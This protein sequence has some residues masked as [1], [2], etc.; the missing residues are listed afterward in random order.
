[1]PDAYEV[2]D[3]KDHLAWKER[4][5]KFS[6]PF[7]E[8][9]NREPG[10]AWLD[11]KYW[12]LHAIGSGTYSATD[13]YDKKNTHF[14]LLIEGDVDPVWID[15]TMIADIDVDLAKRNCR[16]TIV[17]TGVPLDTRTLITRLAD[18]I[19]IITVKELHGIYNPD[20][21]LKYPP[22]E[23][24][25]Y[26]CLMQ[27]LTPDRM[28]AAVELHN[29]KMLDKGIVSFI[30]NFRP[31]AYFDEF[32]RE[33]ASN[34]DVLREMQSWHPR[35]TFHYETRDED[36]EKIISMVPYRSFEEPGPDGYLADVER[37]AQFSIVY[38]TYNTDAYPSSKWYCLTEKSTRS[39][40]LPTI[41]LFCMPRFSLF[42][43]KELGF[44]F[45]PINE[46]L[47]RV[48]GF[49]SQ[50]NFIIG[51]LKHGNIR[52]DPDLEYSIAQHN[53]NVLQSMEDR[54]YEDNFIPNLIRTIN[55]FR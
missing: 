21:E 55:E 42:W 33:G 5:R 53:R 48:S 13:Y 23:M 15:A 16:L 39:L 1:M 27:R 51:M 52:F 3:S 28:L 6:K 50:I 38:E 14:V 19:Q 7:R 20:W 10:M 2:F 8:A 47:N 44:K 34:A 22:K 17:T 37:H 24:K 49:D 11:P 35:V 30:S 18:T 26:S 45:H 9:I 12:T 32:K 54:L 43:Y 40:T 41:S 4:F 31:T 46:S 25:L 29:Q 36:I